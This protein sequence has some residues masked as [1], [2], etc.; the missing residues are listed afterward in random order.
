MTDDKRKQILRQLWAAD[1]DAPSL[2]DYV[3]NR[4]IPISASENLNLASDENTEKWDKMRGRIELV[5]RSEPVIEMFDSAAGAIPVVSAAA[6]DFDNIVREIIYKDRETPP[7]GNMGASFVSGKSLRFIILSNKPYSG[8]SAEEMGL[9]AEEWA[10]KSMEIR[11]YHEC[12]HYYTKRFFG[13]ARN[14]L[15]DELIA[16]FCGIYAA[17]RKYR[18]DWFIKFFERRLPIYTKGLSE[19]AQAVVLNLAK[20][21]AQSVEGWSN[22]QAC[23]EMSEAERIECLAGTEL[24]EFVDGDT[25]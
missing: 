20:C 15:H 7:L 22:T 10:K 8:V 2:L 25:L 9:S 18:A 6:E 11:K 16:D 5:C 3:K 14:N 21:V 24:L 4:F 1:E 23:Q 19:D 12:A 13:S 17:F